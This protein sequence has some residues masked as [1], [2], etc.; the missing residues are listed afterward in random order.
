MSHLSFASNQHYYFLQKYTRPPSTH[1]SKMKAFKKCSVRSQTKYPNQ[2][3]SQSLRHSAGNPASRP[4]CTEGDGSAILP[5][6]GQPCSHLLTHVCRCSWSSAGQC[7]DLSM[8]VLPPSCAICVGM[9]N[10]P[11]LTSLRMAGLS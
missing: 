8:A 1:Q 11:G 4:S 2:D 3:H 5:V 10:W 9:G 7:S 6:P